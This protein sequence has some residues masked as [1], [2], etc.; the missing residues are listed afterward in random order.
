LEESDQTAVDH[1]HANLS[2]AK[3]TLLDF[4]LASF[5]SVLNLQLMLF[6][7]EVVWI[8][9]KCQFVGRG[10]GSE[11]MAAYPFVREKGPVGPSLIQRAARIGREGRTSE[12]WARA[13]AQGPI[14]KHRQFLQSG[15]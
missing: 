15:V 14:S 2:K 5:T 11:V 4:A 1:H 12:E 3:R 10:H 6:R 9:L 8:A 13:A 7:V